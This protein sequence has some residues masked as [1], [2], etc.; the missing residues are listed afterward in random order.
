MDLGHLFLI[1]IGLFALLGGVRVGGIVKPF[2]GVHWVPLP[3]SD[4]V[5]TLLT[6]PRTSAFFEGTSL[7]EREANERDRIHFIA[8]TLARW[9]ALLLFVAYGLLGLLHV[10]WFNR[11]GPFFLFLLTLTLWSL[12][13]TLILWTEPDMEEPQ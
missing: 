3:E 13:Q 7:D 2:R 1:F 6:P 11:I 10:A 4:D 12:P 9:L 8:Y 5:Q